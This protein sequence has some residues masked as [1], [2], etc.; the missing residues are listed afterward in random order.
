MK[1]LKTSTILILILMCLAIFIP[2]EARAETLNMDNN[3]IPIQ[4]SRYWTCANDTIPVQAPTVAD[5]IAVPT[6]AAEAT[7]IFRHQAG[8]IRPA[9]A[10]TA[11]AAN[12]IYVPKD[13][14]IS[15]PVQNTAYI[16]YRSATGAASINFIWKR[17]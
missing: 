1:S 14:Q 16:V 15:M 17:M 11:E 6:D 7:V 10:T 5:S 13:A 3:G 9:A 12:W 4:M 2:R 8:Y